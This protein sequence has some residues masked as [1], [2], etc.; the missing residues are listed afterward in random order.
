M[1][2]KIIFESKEK[3]SL[4]KDYRCHFISFLK[5]V[6]EKANLE[7]IY[8][9]KEY[10]PYTFSVWLG[11]TFKIDEKLH[12]DT[13]IS[14]LFSS[15]DPVVITNFYNGVLKLKNERFKIIGE[16]FEIKDINLL[17]YKK[18]KTN[19]AI[20]KTIGVCVLNNP[21]VQKK[22]FKSWYITPYDDLDKFNEILYQRT[23]DRFKYLTGR[24]DAHPIRLNLLEN[25]PIKEVMVK[26]YNGYVRGFKGVF[27]LS[28][29]PEIL[30]FVYDYGFGIRTGQ[31][32]GLL[33]L[34]KE[35]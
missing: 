4:D 21:Q 12:T 6:F 23:N 27:E 22:D 9:R 34:V 30:Q 14:F 26:H 8:Q 25:Y 3:L 29:S 35:L 2:I 20:F 16:N 31:G 10:R 5:K 18:I 1:K 32:F 11:E 17:P 15:G 33:E 19:K 24:K 7:R 13:K 28:G